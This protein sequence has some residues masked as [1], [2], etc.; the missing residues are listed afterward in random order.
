MRHLG[1]QYGAGESAGGTVMHTC[2]DQQRLLEVVE[3]HVAGVEDEV[4]LVPARGCE[5]A[6]CGGVLLREVHRELQ[7]LHICGAHVLEQSADGY[8]PARNDGS[9]A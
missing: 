7:G 4:L 6:G 1:D 8:L 3:V 5:G 9:A 2:T